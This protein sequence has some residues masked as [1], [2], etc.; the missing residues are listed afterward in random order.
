MTATTTSPLSMLFQQQL[1]E[2]RIELPM[3]PGAAA[4][5]LA[6]TQQESTDAAKLSAVIHKDQTLA[7]NILRIANSAV[8]AGN[9]QCA[10]LQQ[11]VSRLGMQMIT[12]IAMAVSV[13]SRMFD[14]PMFQQHL[15]HLW[16]HSVATGFFTKEIARMRRRNV[17]IAFMC[18]L[19]HDVGKAVLLANLDKALA[20]RR[21][22]PLADLTAALHDHHTTAGALLVEEWQ[23]PDQIGESIRFHHDYERAPRFAE[24]AMMVCLADLMSH[25][26]LGR[27]DGTVLG[28]V[29][30]REHP[31]LAA[32]NIYPDQFDQ[33]AQKLDR[34][35]EYAE[36]MA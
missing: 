12:D 16:R 28:A 10:S 22:V 33:L 19:L 13:K 35:L 11:A 24:M 18:G 25:L 31:V 5:V 21:S 8:F 30:V 1:A 32:L 17:E 9:T 3:L 4:E 26:A 6:L 27:D 14:N 15:E 34:A 23:L 7:S 2:R 20:G 29:A 36:G